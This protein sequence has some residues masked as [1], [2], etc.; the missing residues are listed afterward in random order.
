MVISEQILRESTTRNKCG[1]SNKEDLLGLDNPKHC[2]DLSVSW[3]KATVKWQ[4][5]LR[6]LN[7]K[8]KK[9]SVCTSYPLTHQSHKAPYMVLALYSYASRFDL[10]CFKNVKW[11]WVVLFVCFFFCSLDIQDQES[12]KFLFTVHFSI[13]L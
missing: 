4:S 7:A 11:S 2:Q 6:F 12:L 13:L 10:F 1:E 3:E 8:K 9:K 5:P